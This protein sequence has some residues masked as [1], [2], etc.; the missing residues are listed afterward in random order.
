MGLGDPALAREPITK[1]EP[2]SALAPTSA[3]PVGPLSPL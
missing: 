1:G 3:A 2:L